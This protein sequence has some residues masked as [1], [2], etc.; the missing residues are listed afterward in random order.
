[1][2]IVKTLRQAIK[3]DGRSLRALAREAGISPIQLTRFLRGER[4]LV[5]DTM[6]ALCAVLAL[7]LKPKQPTKR[8]VN[9]GTKTATRQR[10]RHAVST[11]R[12]RPVDR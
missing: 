2:S 1:M 5:T 10:A 4:G 9:S 12:R 7:E 6:D 11:G 8:Q 3:R